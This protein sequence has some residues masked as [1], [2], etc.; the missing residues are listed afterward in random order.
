MD[1]G[2]VEAIAHVPK[3]S[4]RDIA[5]TSDCDHEIGMDLLEDF[6]GGLLAQ[7]VHLE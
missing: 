7:L 6:V 2:G 4:S 5:S 1:R 3:N